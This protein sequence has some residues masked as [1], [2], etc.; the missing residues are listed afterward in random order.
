M[1]CQILVL[2]LVLLGS[3][4]SK[5]DVEVESSIASSLMGEGDLSDLLCY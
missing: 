3:I 5:I 1:T 2:S 4:D